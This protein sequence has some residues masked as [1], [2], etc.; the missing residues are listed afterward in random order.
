MFTIIARLFI[1]AL[2][3][4][5]SAAY[6]PGLDVSGFYIALIVA[7]ILGLLNLTIR[8]ILL[9]LTLPINILT[10]GL[11]SLVINALL[12]WFVSTFVEGFVVAGFLSALI[13]SVI[14][15]VASWA[16]NHV[17]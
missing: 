3:L 6:V 13:G 9:F 1:V 16:A 14:V 12:F 15:A 5:A 2:A 10:F 4:L 7:I 11:F 17:T 8:P